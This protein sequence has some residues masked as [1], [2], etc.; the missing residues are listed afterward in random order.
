MDRP[1]AA[2]VLAGG[3]GTRLYPAARSDRPKQFLSFGDEQSMLEATVERAGFADEVYVLTRPAFRDDV[4][5]L[6]PS[7]TVLTEPEPKDTGPAL[8]YATHRVREDLGPCVVLALPSDHHV[9][10]DFES[11]ARRACRVATDTGRLVTIGIEPDR[12][13]TGY[14]YVEPGADR[15]AYYEVESFTEKPDRERAKRYLEDG[16]YWNSGTFAWT[17][18]SFLDAAADTELGPL[19]SALEEDSPETGYRAV[20]SVSVDYAVMESASGIAV[21]PADYEWDDLGTWDA[22][23]RVLDADADGNAVLGEYLAL[24]ASNNVIASDG[25]VSAIGVEDLVIATF[26][27][28][29]LVVDQSDVQRVRDVVDQLRTDGKF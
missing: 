11:T 16:Y 4:T 6:V 9:E 24:D 10:G 20:P 8:A 28:R 12:P 15:G 1:I 5:E 2:V 3:T 14:G 21:V 27:D 13:A 29:T 7:V 18:E 26:D 23:E 19:V 22:L 25:H 17:P